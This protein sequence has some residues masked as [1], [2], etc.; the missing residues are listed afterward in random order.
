MTTTKKLNRY[1]VWDD[2]ASN[3]EQFSA[4]T[5]IEFWTCDG[6]NKLYSFAEKYRILTDYSSFESNISSWYCETNCKDIWEN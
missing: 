4:Y 5:S 3:Y 6:C 2:K 1:I